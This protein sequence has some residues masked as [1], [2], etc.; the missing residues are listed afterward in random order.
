MEEVFI[1]VKIKF[2]YG[3]EEEEESK[4]EIELSV[5]KE[6]DKEN[7]EKIKDYEKKK[8]CR[9]CLTISNFI[10]KFPNLVKYQELQDADILKIQKDLEFSK[11]INDYINLIKGDLKKKF[12]II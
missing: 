12:L 4:F 6:K 8:E 1:P 11:N 10:D 2:F 9:L 5:F 7:K 3:R